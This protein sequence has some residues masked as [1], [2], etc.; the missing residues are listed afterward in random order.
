MQVDPSQQCD[1]NSVL[2]DEEKENLVKM[3]MMSKSKP[4]LRLG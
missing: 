2:T 4:K 1:T 3:D